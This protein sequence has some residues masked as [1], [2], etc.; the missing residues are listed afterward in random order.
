LIC[1]R[2]CQ[3]RNWVNKGESCERARGEPIP[4][5]KIASIELMVLLVVLLLLLLLLLLLSLLLLILLLLIMFKKGS[6]MGVVEVAVV[7]LSVV[8]VV[9]E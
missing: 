3:A 2:R 6:L 8:V 1:I 9:A 4:C 7:G 5:A